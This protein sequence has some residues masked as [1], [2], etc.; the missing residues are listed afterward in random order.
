MYV[1]VWVQQAGGGGARDMRMSAITSLR[2]SGR[3]LD[4]VLT[5]LH[6]QWHSGSD[7]AGMLIIQL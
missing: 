2:S 6:D 1:T 3:P 4:I 7:N 5:R